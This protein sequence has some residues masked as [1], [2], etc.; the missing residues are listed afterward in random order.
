MAS[1]VLRKILYQAAIAVVRNQAGQTSP[2]DRVAKFNLPPCPLAIPSDL[3]HFS[4][5]ARDNM[6]SQ[7]TVSVWHGMRENSDA[8]AVTESSYNE[9]APAERAFNIVPH[10]IRAVLDA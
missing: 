6:S 5:L 9:L 1:V 4:A 7:T 8:L 2:S 3:D 10:S